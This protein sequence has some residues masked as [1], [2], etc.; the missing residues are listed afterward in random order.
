MNT[1]PVVGSVNIYAIYD[2][3]YVQTWEFLHSN[4][5][6]AH[7]VSY[8]QIFCMHNN[9]RICHNFWIWSAPTIKIETRMH[10]WCVMIVPSIKTRPCMWGDGNKI[11]C[12]VLHYF[13]L[14]RDDFYA[15][16]LASCV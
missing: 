1:G 3:I 5:G 12:Y 6:C 10:A 15:Q 13:T 9:F 16:N 2:I 8:V 14:K 4:L 11:L 7:T